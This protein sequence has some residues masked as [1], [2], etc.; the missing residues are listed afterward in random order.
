MENKKN[1]VSASSK[2]N[3]RTVK[4]GIVKSSQMNKTVVVSV[5]RRVAHPLYRRVIT[6]TTTFLAHDDKDSCGV[7]DTV[8]IVETRPISKLKRWRLLKVIRKAS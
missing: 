1:Q 3:Q 2:N 8:S 4:I 7:G 5:K 6:R